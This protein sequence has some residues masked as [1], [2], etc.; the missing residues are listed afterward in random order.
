MLLG[1]CSGTDHTPDCGTD[2]ESV[3]D[4]H[5]QPRRGDAHGDG[6]ILAHSD[7]AGDSDPEFRCHAVAN[8]EPGCLASGD[9]DAD[10]RA[11]CLAH[12]E[13]HPL[14]HAGA[15]RFADQS[16]HAGADRDA[17]TNQH[18][19]RRALVRAAELWAE[20]A[21]LR[22]VDVILEHSEFDHQHR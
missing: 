20:R 15:H 10:K 18:A 6:S 12:G 21:D 17:G 1:D 8:A 13:S 19:C 4:G 16:P 3:L 2:C 14:A 22:S 5:R 7:L 9:P 11:D